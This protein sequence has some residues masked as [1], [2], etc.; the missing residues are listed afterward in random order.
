[1]PAPSAKSDIVPIPKMW[2]LPEAIRSRLG[3]EAGA[4]R[5]IAE[6]GHLLLILH[7][8]PLPDQHQRTAVFFWRNPQGEW[9]TTSGSAGAGALLSFL[10]EYEKKLM[11]L[12]N[13]ET[14]ANKAKDYHQVL[15]H[16][17][18]ILRASRGLHRALQ[19]ARE[20]VQGDRD[21]ITARDLTVSLERTAELLLQDAQFG[22]NY[23]AAR[24]SETQAEAASQM[25][26][27]AH[28]LNIIAAL[29]L[30]LTAIASF[31]GM[32]IKSGLADTPANF[33]LIICIGVVLGVIVTSLVNSRK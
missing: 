20:A 6:E 25:T 22:L 24:Q 31:F 26:H 32:D 16:L 18:P 3:R 33:W 23:I 14:K 2:L 12:E 11:E 17:A 15:E 5:A 19:Q 10:G 28:R 27:S 4:Q 9:K 21:L 30:P 8:I 13:A 1:M 29:F 7:Q